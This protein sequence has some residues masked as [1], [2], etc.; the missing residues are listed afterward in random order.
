[1]VD[2]IRAEARLK[3]K[4]TLVGLIIYTLNE[5][6]QEYTAR[7]RFDQ[8]Y[9]PNTPLTRTSNGTF[10]LPSNLQV[11]QKDRVYFSEDGN[12]A[13]NSYGLLYAGDFRGSSDGLPNRIQR[14]GNNLLVY[15]YSDVTS[16]SRLYINYWRFPLTMMLPF[17]QLEIEELQ[18]T[19][20]K[21][22]AARMS[23]HSDTE[24]FSL[25]M[26]DAMRSYAA[27]FGVDSQR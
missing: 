20:I 4:D 12:L 8:L 17:D 1:M 7:R 10:A 22:T 5:V 6:L 26:K 16:A 21:E 24:S 23:R 27:S 11:L 9:L 14:V 19:V 25:Q 3:G 2:R 15:P 18:A 13:D